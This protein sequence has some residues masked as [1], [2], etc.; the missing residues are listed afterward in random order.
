[1]E[2]YN[3]SHIDLSLKE[4]MKDIIWKHSRAQAPLSQREVD[5]IYMQV[6]IDCEGDVEKMEIMLKEFLANI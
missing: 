5:T 3:F 1:M 4:I 2:A 6:Y